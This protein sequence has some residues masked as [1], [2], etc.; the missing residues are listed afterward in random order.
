MARNKHLRV[1][2]RLWHHDSIWPRW[3]LRSLNF[4]ED[5]VP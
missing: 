4:L 1:I 2:S 5:D 3:L